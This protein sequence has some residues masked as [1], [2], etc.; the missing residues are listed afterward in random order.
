MIGVHVRPMRRR[1]RKYLKQEASAD[2]GID[3]RNKNWKVA[4][5]KEYIYAMVL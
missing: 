4:V 1:E 3:F 5:T 2:F